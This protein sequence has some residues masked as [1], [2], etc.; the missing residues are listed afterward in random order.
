[1]EEDFESFYVVNGNF[2]DS[3]DL[4]YDYWVKATSGQQ[5][6]PERKVI[7]GDFGATGGNECESCSG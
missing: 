7:L 5:K 1:M 4:A 2:F 6:T 3:R